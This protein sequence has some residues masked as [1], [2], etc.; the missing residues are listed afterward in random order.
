MQFIIAQVYL[1][2]GDM[3]RTMQILSSLLLS[4]ISALPSALATI[5]AWRL[6]IAGMSVLEALQPFKNTLVNN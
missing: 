3:N 1:D 6:Q 4:H 2:H 5:I